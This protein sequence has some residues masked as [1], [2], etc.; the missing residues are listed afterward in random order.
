MYDID[1][2]VASLTLL[3]QVPKYLGVKKCLAVAGLKI[4]WDKV[5][6]LEFLSVK[7]M[8]SVNHG[9]NLVSADKSFV[10]LLIVHGHCRAVVLKGFF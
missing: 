5:C 10:S 7:S 4:S 1:K 9:G 3:A 2:D 6:F 8:W